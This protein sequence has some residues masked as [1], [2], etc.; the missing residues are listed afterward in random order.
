MTDDALLLIDN[1]DAIGD[2]IVVQRHRAI[3]Q[4]CDWQS[5]Q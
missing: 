3:S 4:Q 2:G 1:H 5:V